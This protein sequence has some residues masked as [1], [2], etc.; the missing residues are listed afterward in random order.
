MVMAGPL[1]MRTAGMRSQD[2][3]GRKRTQCGISGVAGRPTRRVETDHPDGQRRAVPPPQPRATGKRDGR[4]GVGP[5][6]LGHGRKITIDS[7]TMMNKALEII[8]ARWLFDLGGADRRGH[9][10]AIG[11]SF[12]GRVPRRL[13]DGSARS[14]GHEIADPVRTDI[15]P[16]MGPPAAKLDLDARTRL[17]FYPPDVERF[18]AF[19]WGTKS[20]GGRHRRGGA[21]RGERSGG[22]RFSGRRIGFTDIVPACRAVLE[23]HN[24]DPSPT[25]EQLLGLDPWARKEMTRWIGA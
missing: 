8:E 5:S 19:S 21:E 2:P 12:V 1:V 25:L 17:A 20:P 11:R 24:Y 13:G 9:S 16:A 22:G 10:S 4:R 6:D 7:A 18:P 15:S 14:A 23:H 3:A